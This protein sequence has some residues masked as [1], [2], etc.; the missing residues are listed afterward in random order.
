MIRNI[1]TYS[2][3]QIVQTP[4]AIAIPAAILASGA[5]NRIIRPS[6]EYIGVE[7]SDWVD[8]SDRS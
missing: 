4:H 8:I 7:S 5:I 2:D 1:F 3:F 6:A